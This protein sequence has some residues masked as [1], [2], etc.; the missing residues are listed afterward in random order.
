MYDCRIHKRIS[1]RTHTLGKILRTA[2]SRIY[3]QGL[4]VQKGLQ[5]PKNA[6]IREC[7]YIRVVNSGCIDIAESFVLN[8]SNRK[9]HVNMY[10]SVKLIADGEG[11]RVSIGRNSR[12][13][14]NCIHA[15][16]AITI[17]ENCLIAAN[18]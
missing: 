2:L 14:G 4:R 5:I 17:G 3:V 9:Y 12:I 13:H 6:F 11:A 1:K 18:C 10:G 8:S 7:F 15:R 16:G